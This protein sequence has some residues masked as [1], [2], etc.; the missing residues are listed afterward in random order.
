MSQTAHHATEPQND[1]PGSAG[2]IGTALLQLF[3]HTAAVAAV[4]VLSERFRLITLALDNA[5]LVKWAPGDKLQVAVAGLSTRTFTPFTRDWST[6]QLLLLG[7]ASGSGPGSEWLKRL[8]AGASCQV[9][10]PRRSLRLR[11]LERPTL[12]VGD[13]TS[14]G[15]AMALRATPRQWQGT[16]FLFEVNDLAESRHV[17]RR[18]QVPNVDLIERQRSAGHLSDMTDV[19]LQ[20][21]AEQAQTGF[22]LTGQSSSLQHLT[23]ALKSGGVPASRMQVKAFWAAGKSGLD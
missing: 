13:E 21:H 15:L 17:L 1:R 6:G 4:Q 14:F 2:M 12:L 22:V 8:Q 16:R 5:L 23:R 7:H 18:L 3:T 19:M 20:A 9:F 10:G 11:E